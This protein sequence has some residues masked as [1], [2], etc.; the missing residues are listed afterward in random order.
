MAQPTAKQIAKLAGLAQDLEQK[1]VLY[2]ELNN[3][4][5]SLER[6]GI[7]VAGEAAMV[8][9]LQL[10]L[11]QALKIL[12][13]LE[14]EA[15]SK[16]AIDL[17]DQLQALLSN[18]KWD[19]AIQIQKELTEKHKKQ[20]NRVREYQNRLDKWRAQIDDIKLII[21]EVRKI[22]APIAREKGEI[23]LLGDLVKQAE[24]S[25]RE[26]RFGLL[27]ES[28]EQLSKYESWPENILS[29]IRKKSQS[30]KEFS[31]QADLLLLQSPLDKHHSY[32]YT[33]LLRT[34]SEPGSQGINIRGS[35]TLVRQDRNAINSLIDNVTEAVNRGLIREF[36]LHSKVE[37]TP[38]SIEQEQKES[39]QEIALDN[40]ARDIRPRQIVEGSQS[41]TG[42]SYLVNDVGDLMYR[43]FMPEQMQTYLSDTPCSITITTNDLELP[44]ELMC[45]QEK[46]LC[47]QRPVAR[48]PMGR[49]FPREYA[50]PKQPGDKLRFL[51][52]YADPA[53][54]LA[55]ASNEIETIRQALEK[56]WQDQI[57]V[58]VIK[59][60]Q[61]SG[62]RLNKELR[63]G[64]YDVIHFA[65]HAYFD[66]ED[67]DLSGLILHDEQENGTRREI[68]FAQK[69]RRLLNGRPLVF[70]NAC[71][72]SRT[73]NEDEPQQVEGYLQTPAEGLA[74]AF[75]YGGAIGCI[76]ALWPV[77]DSPAAEFAISL[78]RRVLEG[79]MI[80]EAMRLTR[81]D[82]RKQHPDSLTWA[83][84]VHYGD[85]TFRLVD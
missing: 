43:L 24:R 35:S 27:R 41:T 62:T 83:S 48:M 57:Q 17:L 13:D 32:Q 61:A 51:L 9:E 4:L 85:P 19:L 31:R 37:T 59:K 49:M 70:L 23:L 75:I 65:G 74:S 58:D 55:A 64:T 72:S 80:G 36:Q 2:I 10:Q 6:V 40:E 54:N 82:S 76:G 45:Y 16:Q 26:Q 46:F 14:Q 34:P 42:I 7:V 67:P 79:F 53:G 21:E 50:R 1:R 84:Y 39:G 78:Y 63:A 15:N 30:A 28:L 12:T 56:Q 5:I 52:I 69:I 3:L 60:E 11:N 29:Q 44:W 81:L 73:A 38:N 66:K 71:H 18:V 33:V 25:L 22:K 20:E 77:Y 68:F 8:D 47:L